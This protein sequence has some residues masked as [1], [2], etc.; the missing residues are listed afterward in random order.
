MRLFAN[1]LTLS[2]LA[3]TIASPLLLASCLAVNP[4]TGERE[5]VLMP[6]S[7]QISMG[8]QYYGPYQQQQGGQYTV[9][10]GLT[11]YV[12][13]IGK[14]LAAVSDQPDLPYEFVVLNDSSPN[15]WALPGGKIAINRGL[16]V[17]LDDEAQL[18]AVIG[19]E[20][21]H[22]AAGHS[23]AQQTRQTL[24]GMGTQALGAVA[25]QTEYG[26]LI[27]MGTQ[28]G[29]GALNAHY[30]RDDELEADEYGV[31]YMER[32]GYHPQAAVELQEKFL[33]LKNGNDGDFMSN[34]LASHPPS[35]ERVKRNSRYASGKSGVRNKAAF[36]QATA[37]LRKDQVAYDLHAQALKYA[38]N[39]QMD[40][41]L[42][43]A[44]QAVKRQPK[45]ALFH[46][47]YGQL[48]LA[49]K[50]PSQAYSAFTKAVQQN[51]N[52]FLPQLMAGL[53]AK[54]LGKKAEAQKYLST[55]L[56]LLPTA[57]A[58]YYLG[59]LALESNKNAAANYFKAA[60][61]DQ[62]EV[63]KA[64]QAQLARLGIGTQ[65]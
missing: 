43:M 39:K 13:G 65:Q 60:A 25:Q 42:D 18:A 40:K 16:L 55:S 44:S 58:N 30:G 7:Q 34:L 26:G 35:G 8:E 1:G 2:R 15:A 17:M 3:A 62:G 32:T 41:A 37:Q 53:S 45:E 12:A 61:T 57:Q 21:V 59:E 4:V 50:Q 6:L 27:M 5:L 29:S 10:P 64:A 48:L 31:K 23:A 28:Y 19:H 14:R 36:Q 20:I 22:A 11:R 24:L 49:N 33:A 56:R 47:A 38:N 9:D 54:E 46:T 52:Y 63:G 51:P